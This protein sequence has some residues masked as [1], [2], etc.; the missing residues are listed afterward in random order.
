MVKEIEWS[1]SS[2]EYPWRFIRESEGKKKNDNF[3]CYVYAMVTN[4][5]PKAIVS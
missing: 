5:T 3:I 4:S 2:K 1:E